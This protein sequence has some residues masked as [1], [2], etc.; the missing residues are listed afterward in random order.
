M[1]T[2]DGAILARIEPPE[3]YCNLCGRHESLCT[4]SECPECGKLNQTDPRFSEQEC[5]GCG[6]IWYDQS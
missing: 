6:A 5:I 4:C 3:V 2:R 1:I